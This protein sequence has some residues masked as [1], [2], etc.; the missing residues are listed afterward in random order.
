MPRIVIGRVPSWSGSR[1]GMVLAGVVVPIAVVAG[2]LFLV[3]DDGSAP[4]GEPGAVGS[5]SVVP[6]GTGSPGSGVGSPSSPAGPVRGTP[7][8]GAA[9]DDA[10]SGFL[11]EVAAINS[12]LV[13]DPARAVASGRA[14]CEAIGAGKPDAEIMTVAREHFKSGEVAITDVTAVLLVTAS[15][16]HLCPG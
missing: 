2:T 1:W 8:P 3:L 9:T 6:S 16:N 14:T 12:A 7:S 15:R 11:T 10:T 4:G 13:A 5:S